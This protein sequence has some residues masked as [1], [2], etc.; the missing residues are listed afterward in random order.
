[1]VLAGPAGVGKTRLASECLV[2]A[3]RAGYSPLR[4]SATS[5]TASVPFGAYANLLPEISG[6]GSRANLL[7]Q[8]AGSI[9]R[10]GGGQ[11]V[12]VM[13]DDAHLLDETSAALTHTLAQGPGTF[14]L[15]TVRSGAPAPDAVV[16]L[17]KDGPAERVE[18]HPL[19][20]PEVGDLLQAALGGPVDGPSF[21]LLQ[22]R[23]NGNALFLKELVLSAL[24]SGSLRESD[25][26]WRLDGD[27]P[28]SARITEIISG[29]LAGLTR[30]ERRALRVLAVGEPLPVEAFARLEPDQDVDDLVLKSL[31]RVEKDDRRLF[32]RMDHPLYGEAL[33]SELNALA[34]RRTA[35]RLADVVESFG[36]RRKTDVLQVGVWRLEGGGPFEPGLLQRAAMAARLRHDFPLAERLTRS[37]LDAGAGFEAAL[38]LGQLKWYQGRAVEAD[39]YLS[40]LQPMAVSDAEKAMLASAR[41][42][43]NDLGLN[44]MD[45]TLRIAEEAERSISDVDKKDQ[46]AADKARSLGRHGRHA[47]SVAAVEPILERAT[48]RTLVVAAFAAGTSMPITGQFRQAIEATEAGYRAHLDLTG[49]PVAFPPDMHLAL[50]LGAWTHA[51]DLAEAWRRA[52]ALYGRAVADHNP[53]VSSFVAIFLS[54][55]AEYQGRPRT[56]LRFAGE[57]LPPLRRIGFPLMERVSLFMGVIAQ[58][59]LGMVDQARAGLLEVDQLHIPPSDLGG[60][61][62]LRGRAWVEVAAGDLPAGCRLLAE[63]VEMARSGGG[64]AYESVVL[65]DLARLGRAAEAA[66]ALQDLCRTVKGPAAFARAAHALALAEASPEGLENVSRKFQEYG[67]LLLAAEASADAA[68]LRRREGDSR[69]ATAAERRAAQL[70]SQCEGATT[71]S[72]SVP[73]PVRAALTPRELEVARLAAGGL[74]DRQ[75][76]KRLYVSHR[77]VENKLHSTYV[78]LGVEGRADLEAALESHQEAR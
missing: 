12:A 34:T 15:A 48:G 39:E 3:E 13:V 30:Q 19:A 63:A 46:I 29:R 1:M 60:P 51:G 77:T 31:V 66:P 40:G 62:L 52:T 9:R 74:S 18:V 20:P 68:V 55:I 23:A 58:A 41:I 14:V 36:A 32:L 67:A 7:G 33:R 65:H 72:L 59:M 16:A 17:W 28:M 21:N 71:P 37:A 70:A 25:G 22:E 43:V 73:A 50:Q 11:P 61:L 53:L 78:K 44:D 10:R 6:G 76:A 8:V 75:I 42:E 24:E 35:T 45:A 57:S 5:A 27:L 4:I 54:M 56:A 47:A 38:L 2:R 69:R 64:R 26:V 49:P